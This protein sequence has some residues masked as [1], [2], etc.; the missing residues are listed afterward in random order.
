MKD[1][2]G[3]NLSKI[4]LNL[5]VALD[6]LLS[7]R[8]VTKAGEKIFVTQS[9]MSV[10]LRQLRELFEDDLLV[11]KGN[12]L[13]LTVLAKEL[14]PQVKEIL[15]SIKKFTERKSF[16]PKISRRSFRIG[17]TE[18]AAFVLLPSLYQYLA[19]HAPYIHLSIK[20]MTLFGEKELFDRNEIDLAIGIMHENNE[21]QSEV[22]F[23]DFLVCAA[24]SDHFLMQSPLSLESYLQ[25][26]HVCFNVTDNT[27]PYITDVILSN[28]GFPR[29]VVLR[30]PHAIS[31]LYLVASS[32]LMITLPKGIIQEAIKILPLAMQ[33][34]PFPVPP[35]SFVQLWHT[36][37]AEDEGHCWLRETIKKVSQKI[38]VAD[39][40]A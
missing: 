25:A 16:D 27:I 29:N 31:A 30:V 5:L 14:A 38:H 3:M 23:T 40:K 22:L 11:R 33:N 15:N 19:V 35:I 28:M 37:D 13:E 17:L 39:E 32:D 4:N 6:S 9:A 34:P 26:K 1:M 24:K 36:R 7:E 2:N 21:L 18:Y 8:N 12:I 10:A 20:P